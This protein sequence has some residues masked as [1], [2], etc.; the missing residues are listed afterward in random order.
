MQQGGLW[1]H[2]LLTNKGAVGMTS[3]SWVPVCAMLTLCSPTLQAL[4]RCFLMGQLT[5]SSRPA[6]IFGTVP[7][8]TPSLALTGGQLRHFLHLGAADKWQRKLGHSLLKLLLLMLV[9]LFNR[10]FK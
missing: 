7:I 9:K 5:S 2:S 6:Q 4:S 1:E 10:S 3:L 8:S